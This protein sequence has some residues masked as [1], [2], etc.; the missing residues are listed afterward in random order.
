MAVFATRASSRFGQASALGKGEAAILTSAWS[1]MQLQ[2]LVPDRPLNMFKMPV[3][4]F[5]HNRQGLG[6]IANSH[7]LSLQKFDDLL[8]YCLFHGPLRCLYGEVAFVFGFYCDN[9]I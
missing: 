4:L 6:E 7:L 1:D 5:F 2:T 8:S 3:D 9:V